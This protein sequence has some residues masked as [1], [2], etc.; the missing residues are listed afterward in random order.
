MCNYTLYYLTGDSF[1]YYI[2]IQY[3]QYMYMFSTQI[4]LIMYLLECCM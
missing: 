3:I 4:G 2:I 1:I